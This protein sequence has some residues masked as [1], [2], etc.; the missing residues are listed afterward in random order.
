M[1]TPF[2][3]ANGEEWTTYAQMVD[4]IHALA[5][6][7]DRTEVVQLGRAVDGKPIYAVAVGSPT[8]RLRGGPV[9]FHVAAQHGNE[10][11][12]YEAAIAQARDLT[13]TT[14]PAIVDT[15]TRVTWLIIP[16][17]SPST[18]GLRKY[19]WPDGTVAGPSVDMNRDHAARTLPETRA[20][21]TALRTY[22]PCLTLDHHSAILPVQW[23]VAS[24]NDELGNHPAVVAASKRVMDAME[25]ALTVEGKTF[26]EFVGVSKN[27]R[28][29]LSN[30]AAY[31]H[32]PTLLL[33]GNRD[34]TPVEALAVAKIALD[35]AHAH[36][37][38][39][40]DELVQASS[41]SRTGLA[42]PTVARSF[43]LASAAVP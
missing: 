10:R 5:D 23:M 30:T 32:S 4:F 39:H 35:A 21:A 26:R 3:E 41:E 24:P 2:E 16:S 38:S 11:T 7:S 36:L 14:D 25:D 15:L 8:P 1:Q 34:D 20:L 37:G 43:G 13:E 6:T 9:A 28:E 42:S 12:S 18:M 27:V 19:I 31:M 17:A 22:R 33:E 29:V 40:L